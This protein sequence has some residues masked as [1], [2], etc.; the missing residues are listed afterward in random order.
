MLDLGNVYDFRASLVGTI[1]EIG[2]TAVGAPVDTIGFSQILAL[3]V[4]GAVNGTDGAL[5]TLAVKIQ[6]SATATAIGTGWTD[7]DDGQVNGTMEF[8]T[9]SHYVGTNEVID[10]QSI[11]EKVGDGVRKR[12]VRAHATASGTAHAAPKF[13]VGFLLGTPVD[14][15]HYIVNPTSQSSGN[16]EFFLGV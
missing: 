11:Y 3:L 14:T 1:G 16:E 4:S 10:C 7:I 5:S 9:I 13:S 8:T 6:E 12:Y 15:I 2:I